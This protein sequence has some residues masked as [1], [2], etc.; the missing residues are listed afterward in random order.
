MARLATMR[1]VAKA[2]G[3]STM[4]V[5]RAFRSDTSISKEA[6]KKILREADRLGYVFDSTASN[7]R[8]QK[9]GFVGVLIPSLNNASF[10]D[11]VGGLTDE[12]SKS[13]TQVLLAYTNYDVDQEELLISQLLQ[14]R[15]D[16]MVLTG[17]QHTEKSR[18]VLLKT[19]IPVIETWDLP[20]EPIGHTVGFSNEAAMHRLVDHM[21]AKGY[22][23]IA[24]V[25]GDPKTGPGSAD[26][27]RRRGFVNAMQQNDL[28]PSR[29]IGWG[30][31]PLSMRDGADALAHLLEK[32]PDT[33]AVIC[34]S[35]LSAFGALT[36]CNRLGVK[37]PD[38]IALAGFGAHEIAGVSVP[39]L[40]TIDPRPRQIGFETARVI[41]ALRLGHEGILRIEVTP[42]LIAGG[43]SGHP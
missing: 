33:E 10:A 32:L 13:G 17:G 24:Y 40:T 19:G 42:E 34:V 30:R 37:V 35:D 29:L 16:A 5:S 11:T 12:L 21:V 36:E 25:G 28:D 8:R 22:R 20:S 9:T 15:P 26:P 14:R 23:R 2:A 39:T 18:N 3:V 41:E 43:S 7:F 38:D 1:D 6:R 27:L 31:S 4:T